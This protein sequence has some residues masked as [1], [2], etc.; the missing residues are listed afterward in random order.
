MSPLARRSALVLGLL[1][2]LVFAVGTGLMWYFDS[3]V[4]YAVTFAVAITL[5]QYAIGP[6]II[7]WVFTIRWADPQEVSPEFADW[8]FATANEIGIPAPRFGIINDGNPNAFTYGRTRGDARL[9]ITSGL[10]DILTPEELRGVVAHELGHVRNRDFIVMTV[11]QAVP[12]VLYVLYV[13]TRDR[14]RNFSYGV[15]ISIGAYLVYLLS[16]FV[17]LSLSR[18]REFFADESSARITGDPN[19][20]SRALIKICYGLAKQQEE[21]ARLEQEETGK[22]KKTAGMKSYMTSNGAAALGIANVKAASRF[23]RSTS[24]ATGA[25]SETAMMNAMQWELKNPWAKWFQLNSTH[26]LT[27]R[28]VMAM[29]EVAK[30]S[31]IAPTYALEGQKNPLQYTGNFALELLIYALP[32]LTALAGVGVF[33]SKFGVKDWYDMLAYAL[34]GFGPGW[35]VKTLLV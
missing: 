32:V 14:G 9:I 7:D 11:A 17:V 10:A 33:I 27:V 5:L 13:W 24:D 6:L 1:F 22:K 12:L 34:I 20:L 4:Y 30:R 2:G 19:S 28:R 3:P 25:F 18:V 21:L 15:A 16:Q 23:A 26:P 31:G 29:N 35:L 8:Y